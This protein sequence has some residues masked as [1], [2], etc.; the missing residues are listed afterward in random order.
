MS[1][2]SLSV[3]LRAGGGL[4]DIGLE[5]DDDIGLEEDDDIGLEEGVDVED[6]NLDELVLEIEGV[7]VSLDLT[8]V[9]KGGIVLDVPC[10]LT[11]RPMFGPLALIILVLKEINF[12]FQLLRFK[13]NS[14]SN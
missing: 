12:K 8:F 1:E 10:T 13:N 14:K 5:E 3:L 6:E 2:S 7:I 11:L 9:G 4:R